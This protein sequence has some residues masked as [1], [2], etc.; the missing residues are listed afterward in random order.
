MPFEQLLPANLFAAFLIFAR[1]G[2]A[3]MLLPGF[4]E[5]YVPQRYRLLLALMMAGLLTPVLSPLIPP[6]PG[7]AATLGVLV[8]GEVAIGVFIGTLAR[9]MVAA[10]ETAG[11]IVSLQTGLSAATMFNPLADASSPL[12]SALYGMLGVVLIFLTDMDH[13]LLRAAVDSYGL[14]APGVLP[15]VGDLSDMVTRFAA[16]SFQLAFEMAAPFIVLGLVFFAA[17]GLLARLVPQLQVLFIA[18]PLQIMGGLV[19]FAVVLVTGMRWFLDAFVQQMSFLVS[20]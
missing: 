1:I 9:M 4:G 17:L 2:S 19:L 20:N 5:L 6:L 15:Q 11:M 3:M 12:P 10:L 8:F 7:S 13:M 18:Q 14:F 16:G